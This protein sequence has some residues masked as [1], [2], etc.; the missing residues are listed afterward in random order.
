[1]LANRQAEGN[2]RCLVALF[3]VSS[4]HLKISQ[5]NF[6]TIRHDTLMIPFQDIAYDE[7]EHKG[8][9]VAM[10]KTMCAT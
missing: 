6:K 3:A 10:V 4:G 1:M 9:S 8:T 5:C 7:L 2:Y